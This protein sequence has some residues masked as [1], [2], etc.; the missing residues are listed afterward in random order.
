MGGYPEVYYERTFPSTGKTHTTDSLKPR[1]R[2]R[3]APRRFTHEVQPSVEHS[4]G[5]VETVHVADG[6]ESLT[7]A[8]SAGA[9]R[10]PYA[11]PSRDTARSPRS[12]AC[13]GGSRTKTDP[14][15]GG[16]RVGVSPAPSP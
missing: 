5:I 6:N 10:E 4:D 3:V 9:A 16:R 11:S 12:K 13:P 14:T 7:A 1:C 15:P 8:A 2:A